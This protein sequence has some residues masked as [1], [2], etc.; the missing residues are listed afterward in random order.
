MDVCVEVDGGVGVG[1]DSK[2]I[3]YGVVHVVVVV[4]VGLDVGS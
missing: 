2:L 3:V 1:V 4:D